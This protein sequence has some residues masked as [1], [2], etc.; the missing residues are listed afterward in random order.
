MNNEIKASLERI[1]EQEYWL[2]IHDLMEPIDFTNKELEANLTRDTFE[3]IKL[4]EGK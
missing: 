3:Q 2:E 4:Y 1:K